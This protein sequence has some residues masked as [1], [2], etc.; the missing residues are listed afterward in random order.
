MYKSAKSSDYD[1]V[2]IQVISST[3]QDLSGWWVLYG[4]FSSLL[5]DL[6]KNL[7]LFSSLSQPL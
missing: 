7:F 1:Y 2:E 5:S 6:E 4:E 3:P